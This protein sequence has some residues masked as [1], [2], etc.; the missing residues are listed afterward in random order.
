MLVEDSFDNG[1]FRT[2]LSLKQ[3]HIELL[4]SINPDN[5]SMALRVILDK[6]IKQTKTMK[7]ERYMMYFVFF[8]CLIILVILLYPV[9]V[10]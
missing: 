7:W 10:I 8:M 3:E 4:K 6:Y 5:Y 1:F 2:S 9:L